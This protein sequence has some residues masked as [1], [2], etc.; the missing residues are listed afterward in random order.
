MSLRFPH[1]LSPLLI[2]SLGISFLILS[3]RSIF[4]SSLGARLDWHYFTTAQ[5][6]KP[7]A[8]ILILISP[9]RLDGMFLVCFQSPIYC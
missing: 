2:I 6:E 8:V 3:S 1:R 5:D 7:N 9:L 4:T